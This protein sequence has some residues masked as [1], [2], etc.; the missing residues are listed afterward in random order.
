MADKRRLR[1]GVGGIALLA[2]VVTACGS[3]TA[4][5]D[6]SE[7]PAAA[8]QA[9]NRA[10]M[11]YATARI[12][13]YGS[14]GPGANPV[15]V[16]GSAVANL[17][18]G[19]TD[20]T[21]QV[22]SVGEVKVRIVH[23][24]MYEKVPD[25]SLSPAAGMWISFD[26]SGETSA[27]ASG[28]ATGADVLG[29]LS[30]APLKSVQRTGHL[31][32]NGRSTTEF[33]VVLDLSRIPQSEL[34]ASSAGFTSFLRS[35]E[36]G[37]MPMKVYV[38]SDG[39]IRRVLIQVKNQQGSIDVTTDFLEYGVPLHVTAPPADQVVPYS[40]AKEVFGQHPSN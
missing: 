2:G 37:T 29:I 17:R 36:C 34:S 8:L 25:D 7:S 13:L 39:L 22:Q 23:G 9:A 40:S 38:D 16:H 28:G 11:T 24:T 31:K 10:T 12:A 20:M 32:V 15:P 19:D 14:E 27:A 21:T 4:T 30:S 26:L 35:M 33:D 1:R 18:T 3:G 6:S 5:W